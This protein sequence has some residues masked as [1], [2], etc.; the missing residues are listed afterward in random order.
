MQRERPELGVAVE[1]ARAAGE[2]LRSRFG[3][4]QRVRYKGAIDLV[5]EAD[6]LAER[7][8]VETIRRHFP[9]DSVLAEEGTTGGTDA[10]RCWMIDPLDGTTNFAHGYP[11]F[12][13]SV[14]LVVRGQVEAG[15]VYDPLRDELF[16][17]Q[18]GGGARL[19]GAPIRV[20]SVDRLEASFL[21]T[22][23]PYDR[24]QIPAALELWRRF[25][26]RAQAVR[27][28]GAAALDL[29]YVAMG[30]F[31]AFWEGV[32]QPWDVAAGGLIV[33]EAGGTLSDY[34]GAPFDVRSPRVVASNGLMHEQLLRLLQKD[35]VV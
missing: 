16:T 9:D 30:R 10:D 1:A 5:T 32:L 20:S 17:A 31:D 26:L 8:V 4:V 15:A 6:E 14:G 21:C 12:A 3:Q 25:V 29:C 11:F 28:D 2:M 33:A 13:V 19:N 27:R 18:L 34:A 35:D 23:F 22:G 7:T 24:A